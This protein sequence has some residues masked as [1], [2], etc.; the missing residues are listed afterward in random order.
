MVSGNLWQQYD[1]L[2]PI[3]STVPTSNRYEVLVVYEVNEKD[4]QEEATPSVYAK[5][6]KREG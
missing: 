6:H 3:T 4:L 5:S 2:P 1:S